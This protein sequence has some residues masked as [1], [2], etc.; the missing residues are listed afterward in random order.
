LGKMLFFDSRVSGTENMNCASCRNPS[1][2]W[3]SS[4]PL[5]IGALNQPVA[6][7]APTV[8]NQAWGHEFFWDGRASSLEEQP[9]GPIM[10]AGEMNMDLATLIAR[11]R[12]VPDYEEL[13]KR[14]FPD[15]GLTADNLMRAIATYERTWSPTAPPR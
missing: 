7:H 11:I 3:E 13:F 1:F 6:R 4:V 9:S 14:A 2:G 10:A 5:A 15:S 8:L 12:A